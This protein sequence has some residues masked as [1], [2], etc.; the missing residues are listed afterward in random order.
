LWGRITLGYDVGVSTTRDD[1]I[2]LEFLIFTYWNLET[3]LVNRSTYPSH[4]FAMTRHS[5]EGEGSGTVA[6]AIQCLA[7]GRR[8]SGIARG[9]HHSKIFQRSIISLQSLHAA[10][11]SVHIITSFEHY[12]LHHQPPCRRPTETT[13]SS[14]P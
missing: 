2:N 11:S 8:G 9:A 3:L 7:F 14:H 1:V 6:H 4:A 12:F 5:R 10:C 13:T